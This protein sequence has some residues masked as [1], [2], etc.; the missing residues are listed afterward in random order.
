MAMK[1]IVGKL[2]EMNNQ[3]NLT[4]DSLRPV[5]EY[6]V[7]DHYSRKMNEVA[8]KLNSMGMNEEAERI[9]DKINSIKAG[10][11]GLLV[12]LGRAD[13]QK[14]VKLNVEW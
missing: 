12:E 2:T 9:T 7:T 8:S 6:R 1:D 10:T 11:K 4:D 5:V 3:G 14:H 13:N